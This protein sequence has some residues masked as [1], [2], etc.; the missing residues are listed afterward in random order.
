[1][2]GLAAGDALAA[3]YEFRAPPSGEARM[4]GG[5]LGNWEP[6]EWTDDTQMAVC[7]AEEAATG[8]V[9]VDKVADRFLAWYQEGPKDVGAQTSAVLNLAIGAAEVAAAATSG[10]RTT[11]GTALATAA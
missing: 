4:I 10:T 6:G 8:A 11:R 7:I 1:M 2:L 3:G 9:G 5:G